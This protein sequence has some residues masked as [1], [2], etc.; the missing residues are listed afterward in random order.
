[1]PKSKIIRPSDLEPDNRKL[2]AAAQQAGLCSDEIIL[3]SLQAAFGRLTTGGNG[4]GQKSAASKNHRPA[5][6]KS[7]GKQSLPRARAGEDGNHGGTDGH[8]KPGS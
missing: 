8:F 3:N 6:D 7:A 5:K 1:M 2:L 4:R